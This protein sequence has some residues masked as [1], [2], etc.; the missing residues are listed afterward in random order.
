MKSYLGSLCHKWPRLSNLYSLNWKVCL[1]SSNK[2][3]NGKFQ[4][5]Y[6]YCYSICSLSANYFYSS[7]R[8]RLSLSIWCVYAVIVQLYALLK[9]STTTLLNH[10]QWSAAGMIYF[11]RPSWKLPS[12]WFPDKKIS[13]GKHKFMILTCFVHHY[14]LPSWTPLCDFWN[15]T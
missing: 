1:F 6:F 11:C 8:D 5:F 7:L 15:W 4:R 10:A 9:H 12:P 13:G 14:N 2:Q 3:K